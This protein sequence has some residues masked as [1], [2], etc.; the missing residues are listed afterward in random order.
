[1]KS[2]GCKVC[3]VLGKW[4]LTDLE[5]ELLSRWRGEHGDRM[6][7]RKLA[8]WLNVTLLRK[9][10]DRAGLTTVGGAATARYERLNEGGESATTVRRFL[11]EEGLAVDEIERDF[12]SYGVVRTHLKECLDA[13]RETT[14][15]SD[16]AWTPESL[17]HTRR[18]AESKV[19]STVR[20]GINA[21][22]LVIGGKP[23]VSVSIELTCPSC[24]ATVSAETALE[25][26]WTC[27]CTTSD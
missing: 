27:D 3:K 25:D 14:D 17:A 7:Y 4:E 9:E 22:R 6:G 21:E 16:A 2:T 1:M 26:G 8:E 15:S 12:V 10:M 13:E 20:A 5:Q 23:R 11:H 18:F 19:E 24:S